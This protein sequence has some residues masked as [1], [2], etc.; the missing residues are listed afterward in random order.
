MNMGIK[1][2]VIIIYVKFNLIYNYKWK[3]PKKKKKVKMIIKRLVA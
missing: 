3:E 2:I 1:Y